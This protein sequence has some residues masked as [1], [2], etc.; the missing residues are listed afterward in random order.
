MVNEESCSDILEPPSAK[1][2]G[3]GVGTQGGRATPGETPLTL[4]PG[5]VVHSAEVT[6]VCKAAAG[7]GGELDAEHTVYALW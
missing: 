1:P 2:L 3:R 7:E 4:T 5:L 6:Q